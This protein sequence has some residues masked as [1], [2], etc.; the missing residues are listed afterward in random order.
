MLIGDKNMAESLPI[1]I[2]VC[3][4][5]T[6]QFTKI[7]SVTNKLTAQFNFQTM[8]ANWYNDEANIWF[9][10]LHIETPQSFMYVKNNQTQHVLNQYSDDVFSYCVDNA[11]KQVLMCYIAVTNTEL[12]LLN[13]QQKLL[14]GLFTIKLQKVLNLIAKQ[15]KFN[16]I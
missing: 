7:Y 10:Q 4:E 13:Q 16:T 15:L 12:A 11:R 1:S 3:D 5:L 6:Q 9:V 2:Y 14:T 8:G